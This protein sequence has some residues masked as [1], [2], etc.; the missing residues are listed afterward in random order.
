MLRCGAGYKDTAGCSRVCESRAKPGTVPIYPKLCRCVPLIE[1]ICKYFNL[2][3]YLVSNI[4]YYLVLSC[5]ILYYLVLS[6]TILYYLVQQSIR[7]KGCLFSSSV[8]GYGLLA[9][10]CWPP[11]TVSATVCQCMSMFCL[12]ARH[13]FEDIWSK[14]FDFN[15]FKSPQVIGGVTSWRTLPIA[16]I[17]I[18]QQ[19]ASN[20]LL[21]R[22]FLDSRGCQTLSFA[23][24]FECAILFWVFRLRH[25][26]MG[27]VFNVFF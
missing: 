5:T 20:K 8:C 10:L 11:L 26:R 19:K 23:V 4:L 13:Q 22:I 18:P 21:N 17:T 12:C 24:V 25:G 7:R 14:L 3:Y 9:R 16:L 6:C 15:P 2:L 27:V 1:S